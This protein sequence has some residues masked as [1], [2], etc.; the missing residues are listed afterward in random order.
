MLMLFLPNIYKICDV[1]DFKSASCTC[2][3]LKICYVAGSLRS[4]ERVYL[5]RSFIDLYYF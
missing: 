2:T 5:P 3:V 4:F 1:K